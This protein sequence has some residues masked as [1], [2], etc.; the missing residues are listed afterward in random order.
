MNLMSSTLLPEDTGVPFDELQAE[1][2]ALFRDA[3]AEAGRE[4]EPRVSVSRSVIPI[5]SDLDRRLFG[6][7]RANEDQVGYLDG[8]D[9]PLRPQLHRR[10]RPDRRGARTRRGG[11]GADT[12]AADRAEPARRRV[13]R[14]D[15]GDDRARDR[16]GDRLDAAKRRR[17]ARVAPAPLRRD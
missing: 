15:A 12:A 5:T 14:R 8:G 6:A 13:Q 17:A 2:I 9:Q 3:W 1:Q 16:A 10:A 4:R 11:A 7:R